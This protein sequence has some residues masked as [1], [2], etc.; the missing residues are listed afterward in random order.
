MFLILLKK[1]RYKNHEFLYSES[2]EQKKQAIKE[3]RLVYSPKNEV[4]EKLLTEAALSL[5]LK[6]VVGVDT[7]EELEA[8]MVNRQLVAG[9]QFEHPSVSIKY[10]F[11]LIFIMK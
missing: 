3:W 5:G 6:G 1:Y 9:V 11:K 4:F 2:K 7:Q 8:T 10:F